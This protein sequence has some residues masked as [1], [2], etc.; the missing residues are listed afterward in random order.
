[1]IQATRLFLDTAF[2]QAL[3]NRNDQYHPIAKSRLSQL[4]AAPDVWTTEAILVEIGN[5]L[6]RQV[7]GKQRYA[8]AIIAT[9]DRIRTLLP[10]I[11]GY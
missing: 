11:Q 10:W 1:M 9:P 8:S 6:R 4:R 7:T 5:A 2:V 3:L